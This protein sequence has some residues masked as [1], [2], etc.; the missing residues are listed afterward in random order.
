MI[1]EVSFGGDCPGCC[2]AT[3]KVK[4]FFKVESGASAEEIA[5]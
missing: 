4:I 3:I 5:Q 1:W 2:P